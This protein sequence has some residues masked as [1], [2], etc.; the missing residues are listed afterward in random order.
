MQL[1]STKP[2]NVNLLNFIEAPLL[3]LLIYIFFRELSKPQKLL[4]HRSYGNSEHF[5]VIS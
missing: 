4:F 3:V 2:G 1:V 5:K